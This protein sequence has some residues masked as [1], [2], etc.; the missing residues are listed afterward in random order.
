[1]AVRFRLPTN[2]QRLAV[3]GRTGSGKTQFSAWVLSLA[4]YDKQ[5]YIIFDWKHD[6]LLGAIDRAREIR[7]GEIPKQPGL[8]IVRP[9]PDEHEEVNAY[10]WRIWQRERVGLYFDES[11]N[12]PDP[13]KRSALRA[14]LT[15]G[16]SKRIPVIACTQRP[17]WISRFI[18]SEAD[19]IC[20]FHVSTPEDVIRVRQ[21]VPGYEPHMPQ[22]TSRWFDVTDNA[23]Y[24]MQ[25]APDA[26]T[27]LE[28]FDQRLQPKRRF[29]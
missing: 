12:I 10:L 11:Y 19:F 13:Q 8:Y 7:L 20:S 24:Q 16:R 9:L 22:Y 26:E 29:F 1:M 4:P 5:P 23:V 27:I 14:V 3:V 21:F 25:P 2:K 28:T 15:Q 18:F 17:A 6:E